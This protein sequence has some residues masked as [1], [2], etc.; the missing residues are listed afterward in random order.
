VTTKIDEQPTT[1]SGESG[2]IDRSNESISAAEMA[3]YC[4]PKEKNI[5]AFAADRDPK[6]GDKSTHLGLAE[7]VLATRLAFEGSHGFCFS[8]VTIEQEIYQM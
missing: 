7:N 8:W 5:T 3:W 1:V 2:C 4:P 6:V